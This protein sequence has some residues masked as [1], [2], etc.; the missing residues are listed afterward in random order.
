MG[1]S[2]LAVLADGPAEDP[3]AAAVLVLGA[4][5]ETAGRAAWRLAALLDAGFLAG[6]GWDPVTWVLSPPAGHRLIRWDCG[7]LD[8][9]ASQDVHRR[10]A[11]SPVL[12][13]GKCAA[14]ARRTAGCTR[15]GGTRPA[16]PI[17]CLTS[18]DGARWPSRSP[19]RAK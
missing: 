10:D 19:S 12:G 1:A 8:G 13:P 15:A 18:E 9:P 2:P 3:A 4:G 5:G 7:R 17:R 6:A 16:R 14:G 11:P